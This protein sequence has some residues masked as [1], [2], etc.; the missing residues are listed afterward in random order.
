MSD[1]RCYAECDKTLTP[2]DTLFLGPGSTPPE[3]VIP[4]ASAGQARNRPALV[5]SQKHV[6][7][8]L[9]LAEAPEHLRSVRQVNPM[10]SLSRGVVQP[11]H[12]RDL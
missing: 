9:G 4:Y 3:R 7:R 2:C 8:I 6:S 10:P 1:A 12:L 11:Q 5:L